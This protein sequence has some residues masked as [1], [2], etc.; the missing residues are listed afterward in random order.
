MPKA[1]REMLEKGYSIDEPDRMPENIEITNFDIL[2]YVLA[3]AGHFADMAVDT[4]IAVRYYLAHKYMEFG[5]TFLFIVLPA[6]VNTAV[7]AR[8]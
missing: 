1:M 3:I 8:M 7:S 5:W 2:M 4:N 6:V